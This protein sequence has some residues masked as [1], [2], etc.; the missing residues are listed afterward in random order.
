MHTEYNHN[1]MIAY[2]YQLYDNSDLQY[3]S[4]YLCV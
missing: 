3:I 2:L 4:I 1:N